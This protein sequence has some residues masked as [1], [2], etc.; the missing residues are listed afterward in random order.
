MGLG[1]TL[2]T[3]GRQAE[4]IEAYRRATVLRPELS[5]AWWSLSNL[6]TFRFED[7]EIET[8]RAAARAAGA[9]RRGARAV[10]LRAGQGA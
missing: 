9:V 5:E 3:V 6:K 8:M 10:L 1:N 2:K 4:A 7:E